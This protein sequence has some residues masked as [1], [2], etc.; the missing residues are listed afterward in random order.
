MVVMP[1]ASLTRFE[2]RRGGTRAGARYGAYVGAAIGLGSAVIACAR[3]HCEQ[4]TGAVYITFS[5]T[6]MLAGFLVGALV[7]AASA[8]WEQVPLDR[9][10]VSVAPRRDGRFGLGLSVRF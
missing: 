3:K 9:L 10:R 4:Y 8:T 7:G 5:G 2:V 6:G 1:L